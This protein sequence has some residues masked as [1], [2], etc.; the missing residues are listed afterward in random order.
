MRIDIFPLGWIGK[1]SNNLNPIG[2]VDV[3]SSTF[4]LYVTQDY[5]GVCLVGNFIYG[6]PQLRKNVFDRLCLQ[7]SSG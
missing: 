3:E 6:D 1:S 4:I 5:F 2:D 7:D